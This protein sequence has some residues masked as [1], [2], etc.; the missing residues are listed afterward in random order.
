[1]SD[2]CFKPLGYIVSL[3]TDKCSFKK[4]PTKP[5]IGLEHIPSSGSTLQGSAEANESIS[6]NNIFRA[7]DILFGKLRPRLRKS[8]RAP[9][10]GYCSTDIIVLRPNQEVYSDFAG[11]VLQSD[12]VFAK[13]I[14][15]EEGTKMPRCS[16]NTL[17]ELEV[18]CPVNLT[19]QKRIAIILSSIDCAIDHTEALIEKYQQIK[20]GL[21]H[22]LFTRGIGADGK[23]RPPRDQA[24]EL[25]QESEIGW[26]PRDW[27]VELIISCADVIDPNPSHRNPIYHDE[28]FPFISTVEFA[29][30]D[31]IQLDTSRRVIEEIVLEQEQRCKFSKFSIAF[32][33]KGTIGEIRLLPTHLRFALLD[34]L[35]VVNPTTI[36]PSFLFHL[37][38]SH[39][40]KKQIRTM[41]MGQALPQMSIGRVR[42]L[43]I[44]VPTSAKEQEEIKSKINAIDRYIFTNGE[45]LQ[46]LKS[47]KYGLMHDLLTGKVPVKVEADEAGHV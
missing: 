32:S 14:R 9:F 4:D 13:A 18:F 41:T 23:L 38:R 29:E 22:D 20:A 8:V 31:Q 24:P 19:R 26:I 28:G 30:F 45:D 15:T 27:K 36:N 5:Y 3:V 43:F 47:K 7:G 37:L 16:W 1:M 35:C 39:F 21:M 11:F 44:P 42:E 2:S 17:Q 6:V 25:Y 33:R 10:D 46:K 40:L 12:A 34:S